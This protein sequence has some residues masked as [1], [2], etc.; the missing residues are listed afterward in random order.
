MHENSEE[1]KPEDNG[2]KNNDYTATE[3]ESRKGEKRQEKQK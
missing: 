2:M 3:K 1:K